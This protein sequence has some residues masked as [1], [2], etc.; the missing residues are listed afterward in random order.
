M[1][2][3]KSFP[4]RNPQKSFASWFRTFESLI[5]PPVCAKL[6]PHSCPCI[7]FNSQFCKTC[8]NSISF[9]VYEFLLKLHKRQNVWTINTIQCFTLDVYILQWLLTLWC[10]YIIWSERK[11]CVTIKRER[12]E[13]CNWPCSQKKTHLPRNIQSHNQWL[14]HC[15]RW[16]IWYLN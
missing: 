7:S 12:G 14:W 6:F 8:S 15:S 3:P 2:N 16:S 13:K 10:C 1:H 5:D 9:L 4:P 11:G